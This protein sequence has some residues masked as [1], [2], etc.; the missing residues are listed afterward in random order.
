MDWELVKMIFACILLGIVGL[1]GLALLMAV[2][3][4]P[5]WGAIWLIGG[6]VKA[7]V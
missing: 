5:F 1:I 6:I 4:I 2:L 7:I 3:A